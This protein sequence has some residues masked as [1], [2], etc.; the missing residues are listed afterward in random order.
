[1][2]VGDLVQPRDSAVLGSPEEWGLTDHEAVVAKARAFHGIGVI[3]SELRTV[4]GVPVVEI[5]W[6]ALGAIQEQPVNTVEVI[7]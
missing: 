4:V 6:S 2:K 1:M 7:S 5:L 3:I